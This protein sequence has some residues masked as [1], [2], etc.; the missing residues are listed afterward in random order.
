MRTKL[1]ISWSIMI[2]TIHS[3]YQSFVKLC[4]CVFSHAIFI[5]K[6]FLH[7]FGLCCELHILQY[8][9]HPKLLCIV[10]NYIFV[11]HN[12]DIYFQHKVF[13]QKNLVFF[14]I[15]CNIREEVR[16]LI[17]ITLGTILFVNL[18]SNSQNSTK[19]IERAYFCFRSIWTMNED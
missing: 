16:M 18:T 8:L 4:H 13:R 12:V 7:S 11:P 10:W 2:L 19:D 1:Y 5:Q 17:E 14:D 6:A 9:Q 3:K 15:K